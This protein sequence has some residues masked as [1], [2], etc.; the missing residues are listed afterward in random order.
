[1][2]VS[3]FFAYAPMARKSRMV[4]TMS[5][6]QPLWTLSR[7]TDRAL[8]EACEA[9]TREIQQR[10]QRAD[11]DIRRECEAW[12]QKKFGSSTRSLAFAARLHAIA[13]WTFD[14]MRAF[15]LAPALVVLQALKRHTARV[16]LSQNDRRALQTLLH[17]ADVPPRL[18]DQVLAAAGRAANDPHG[19]AIDRVFS[20]QGGLAQRFFDH[21]GRLR[22]KK[23]PLFADLRALLVTA[24]RHPETLDQVLGPHPADLA[25]AMGDAYHLTAISLKAAFPEQFGTL[26]GD[27]VKQ[28]IAYHRA[29]R[30]RPP[31]QRPRYGRV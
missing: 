13:I 3:C 1:M 14:S 15:A 12:A 4:A 27:G 30:R 17:K 5:R 11:A 25:V 29:M 19:A 16:S 2:V 21:R 22:T 18:H 31:R 9:A 8:L 6:R 28:A 23:L 26:D 10:R 24:F 20:M 7:A